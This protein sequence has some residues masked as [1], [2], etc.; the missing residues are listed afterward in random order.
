MNR[1][2]AGCHDCRCQIT[3]HTVEHEGRYLT[4]RETAFSCGARMRETSDMERMI[5]KVEFAGCCCAG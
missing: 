5:G 3:S 4:T 2:N 1:E